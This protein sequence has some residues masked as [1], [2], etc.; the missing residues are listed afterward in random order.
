M[1]DRLRAFAAVLR[2]H[3]TVALR[4]LFVLIRCIDFLTANIQQ[5]RM[6]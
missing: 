3:I 2:A 5:G 6:D 1:L 4:A